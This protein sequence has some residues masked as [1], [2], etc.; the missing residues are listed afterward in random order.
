MTPT[1]VEAAWTRL[2]AGESAAVADELKD[3]ADE[4][5]T[6]IQLRAHARYDSGDWAGAAADWERVLALDEQNPVARN[7]L[8]LARFR[9]GDAKGAADLLEGAPLF[10]QAGFLARFLDLFWP[11]RGTTGIARTNIS[12]PGE[13][14]FSAEYAR[15]EA[16]AEKVAPRLRRKLAGRMM[17]EGMIEFEKGRFS[18]ARTLFDRAAKVAPDMED[19]TCASVAMALI[20]GE[21]EEALDRIQPIFAIVLAA[22]E[23]DPGRVDEVDP[24]FVSL[25]GSAL[26]GVGRHG[27]ALR[28]LAHARP[29]GPDDW[30]AHFVAAMCWNA[31][32]RRADSRRLLAIALGPFFLPTWETAIRPFVLKTAKWLRTEEAAAT[33]AAGVQ[34]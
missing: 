5:S 12:E 30:G 10:P 32:G 1:Q 29:A 21:A 17:D 4:D 11:L 20:D 34:A 7:H 3:L 9:L 15:F 26:H 25:L 18:S 22:L 24:H 8:A 28:V 31:I 14:P 19:A 13:V 6:S 33:A 2:D 27:E 23:K 16:H